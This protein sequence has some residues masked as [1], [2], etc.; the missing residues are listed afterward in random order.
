MINIINIIVRFDIATRLNTRG[1]DVTV[2]PNVFE[3]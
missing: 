2:G 3:S 1:F